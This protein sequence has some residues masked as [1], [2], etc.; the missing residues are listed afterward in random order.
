MLTPEQ[1]ARV[2]G[3]RESHGLSEQD[4]RTL[5]LDPA[6]A[7]FFAAALA[8]HDSPR[9]V[10]NW[11]LNEL[12]GVLPDGGVEALPFGGR[13]LGELVGLL[14][15]GTIAGPAAKEVLADLVEAGGRP[16]EIVERRGLTQLDD[17]R[18]LEALVDQVLAA[19]PD[20]VELYRGGKTAILGFFVGQVMKA[21]GGRANPRQVQ[22]LVKTRLDGA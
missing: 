5:A 14:E 13:E 15:G 3:L 18:E 2:G 21:S 19:H 4:A 22:Q 12:L 10:A 17:A 6:L 9:G 1:Q 8:V 7:S 11:L 20:N 16:A